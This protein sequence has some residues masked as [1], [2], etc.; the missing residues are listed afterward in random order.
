[1]QNAECVLGR[2][3]LAIPNAPTIES[4]RM[5]ETLDDLSDKTAVRDQAVRE[6]VELSGAELRERLTAEQVG[7]VPDCEA[8]IRD[9]ACRCPIKASATWLQIRAEVEVR[10]VDRQ[11]RGRMTCV[12]QPPATGKPGSSQ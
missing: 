4:A 11:V 1:M 2:W 6:N 9:R 3:I 8:D 7:Q 5:I 10:F 12:D